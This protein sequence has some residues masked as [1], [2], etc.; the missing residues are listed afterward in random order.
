MPDYSNQIDKISRNL[1]SAIQTSS[2]FFSF[3]ETSK[4]IDQNLFE[5]NFIRQNLSLNILWIFS[6]QRIHRDNDDVQ[7]TCSWLY[8]NLKDY[9]DTND[10]NIISAFIIVTIEKLT[11]LLDELPSIKNCLKDSEKE[12][13]RRNLKNL[14]ISD[15]VLNFTNTTQFNQFKKLQSIPIVNSFLDNYNELLE[16]YTGE[17]NQKSLGQIME[18][19]IKVDD[20]IPDTYGVL[21]LVDDLYAL[22]LLDIDLQINSLSNIKWMFEIEYPEFQFPII[23]DQDGNNLINRIDA[24]IK[25]S[26][27]SS[28]EKDFKLKYFQLSE[29][30]PFAVL[31]SIL[32]P[33]LNLKKDRNNIDSNISILEPGEMYELIRGPDSITVE[34]VEIQSYNNKKFYMFQTDINKMS[35]DSEIIN[36]CLLKKVDEHTD[37]TRESKVKDFLKKSKKPIHGMFPFGLANNVDIKF[38]KV[39]LVDKKNRLDKYLNIEIE[40]KTIKEWFGCRSINTKLK[41]EKNIGFL[42]DE[43]LITVAYSLDS[44]LAYIAQNSYEDNHFSALNILLDANI[45]NSLD[46]ISY[47]S[48]VYSKPFNSINIFTDKNNDYANQALDNLKFIGF[49]EQKSKEHAYVLPPANKFFEN[50][51]TKINSIPKIEFIE[52]N[53]SKINEFLDLIDFQFDKRLQNLKRLL[54]LLKLKIIKRY[55]QLSSNEKLYLEE[56]LQKDINRLSSYT[57]VH[58]NIPKIINFIEN[59]IEFIINYERFNWIIDHLNLTSQDKFLVTN[60][61]LGR[62]KAKDWHENHIDKLQLKDIDQIKHLI[63]PAFIDSKT[64]RNLINFP[65]A[66]K[67]TFVASKYE[68]DKY[69]SRLLDKRN[70]NGGIE[71]DKND[72]TEL[73]IDHHEEDLLDLNFEFYKNIRPQNEASKDLSRARVFLFENETALALPLGGDQII[74]RQISNISPEEIPVDNI[75]VGDF[76]LMA[77]TAHGDLQDSILNITYKNINEIRNLAF[78][79]KDELSHVLTDDIRFNELMEA[80]EAIDEKR[81]H[82]TVKNW[83]RSKNLIAPQ[84]YADIFKAFSKYLQKDDNYLD[85]C[86]SAV[87]LLYT[88]RRKVLDDLPNYLKNFYYDDI[89]NQIEFRVNK[90]P[91][92]AKIYEVIAYQDINI[93]SEHIYKIQNLGDLDG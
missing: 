71:K 24:L 80:L 10:Y 17:N 92:I 57:H 56:Q 21:G 87:K 52:C 43:P 82:L 38:K 47:L 32:N 55:S 45:N 62:L 35:I 25:A 61:E 73:I 84:N 20:V 54:Y 65:Y 91:F 76:L 26:L 13:I 48:N 86:M 14:N 31:S 39:F 42:S 88:A 50:Y 6:K 22:E 11:T 78:K 33:I 18:Y 23:I 68:I 3:E 12:S 90:K 4:W 7:V 75:E 15:D 51:L 29:P 59:N 69:L 27:Y 53:Q 2:C 16:I 85:E 93:G 89:N 34:F 66:E 77:D 79:W 46:S 28:I 64:T 40:G 49:S 72:N 74:S 67:I 41:E 60:K 5:N 63:I 58:E 44:S 30:G 9:I 36:K 19:I 70:S 37:Y 81:H 8:K 83:F 1:D